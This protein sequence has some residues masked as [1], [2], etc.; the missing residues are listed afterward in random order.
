LLIFLPLVFALLTLVWGTI[1]QHPS[2]SPNLAPGWPGH[3]L[4]AL[5]IAQLAASIWVVWLMKGYRLF[6]IFAVMLELWF[7]LGCAFVAGMSVTG[8]WL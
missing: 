5:F 3:V 4:Q 1:M 8:D 7:A 2:D 6:S